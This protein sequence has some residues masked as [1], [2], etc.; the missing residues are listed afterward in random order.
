LLARR[1]LTIISALAGV[2]LGC[3]V[4]LIAGASG[5]GSKVLDGLQERLVATRFAPAPDLDG[6][7]AL[8]KAMAR[9]LFNL[10]TGPNAVAETALRVDGL[11]IQSKRKAALVAI[12]GQPANWLELGEAR[13]NVTLMEIDATWAT[14][15]TPTGFKQVNLASGSDTGRDGQAAAPTVQATRPAPPRPPLNSARL[16]R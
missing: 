1:P 5:A 6:S 10:T 2:S 13:D 12:N 9:P 16:G 11:S 14:F 7:D 15:D 4:W 3:A 8:A